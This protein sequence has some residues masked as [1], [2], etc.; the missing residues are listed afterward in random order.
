MKPHYQLHDVR[1]ITVSETRVAT[2]EHRGDP[3]GIG[4]SIRRFIAWR[5]QHQLPPRL[6]ATFNILYDNPYETELQ[7][8][9]LDLCAGLTGPLPGNDPAIIEKRIPGGRCAALRHVGSDDTLGD[10]LQ[11]LYAQWL[12]QSGEEPREFPPYVQRLRFFPDVPEAEAETEA[13]LPLA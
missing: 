2:F 13:Y 9:R 12:P 6:S 5:K 1:I 4:D 10:T 3:A 8:F 11:F 7:A